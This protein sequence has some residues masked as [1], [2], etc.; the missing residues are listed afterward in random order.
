MS[1]IRIPNIEHLLPPSRRGG[2]RPITRETIAYHE[3]GHVLASHFYRREV[4]HAT[5][6]PQGGEGAANHVEFEPN[7][8][9]LLLVRRAGNPL[10]LWP[11]ALRQTRNTARILFAGPAAQAIQQR[12]SFNQVDGG[13]DQHSAAYALWYLEDVRRKHAELAGVDLQHR[14]PGTLDTLAADARRLVERAEHAP[15]LTRVAER[16]LSATRI[17]R[18]EIRELL[19]D[20][21]RE[22]PMAD[23]H[24]QLTQRR[25][26]ADRVP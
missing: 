7:R 11:E 23:V 15:F 6:D 19:Q 21:P 10:Q 16:L 14:R 9:L 3:A 13:D 4:L 25:L 26:D 20:M 22:D 5:L 17:E 12:V 24:R 1:K 8:A 18:E 2:G